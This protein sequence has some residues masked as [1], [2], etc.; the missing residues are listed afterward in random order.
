MSAPSAKAAAVSTK[1]SPDEIKAMI[2]SVV[3]SNQWSELALAS[4][5]FGSANLKAF[6]VNLQMLEQRTGLSANTLGLTESGE[7][8]NLD[9]FKY[10]TLGVLGFSCVSGV[11]ALALLPQNVGATV[12]YFVALLPI[13]WLAIGSSAPGLIA[14]AIKQIKQGGDDDGA[15][16]ASERACR[17]EA[18]HFCCGYWCGLPVKS[19]DVSSADQAQVEFAVDAADSRYTATTVAALAVTGL[20]GLVGEA[21]QFGNA[22]GA[23]QDLLVLDQVFRQAQDFYG[24][25]QQQDLTR[26]AALTA[27]LLLK[28]NKEKYEQVHEAFTRKA[29]L[30]ECIGILES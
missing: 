18:A 27:S 3:A 25:Q 24:A 2:P 16:S 5:T 23:S 7:D 15:I 11:A 8:V 19:Y 13:V 1:K 4:S 21:S 29:T 10:A 12:C 9:D 30:E 22:K 28:N 26:W 17:H 14:G 6:P 20:A